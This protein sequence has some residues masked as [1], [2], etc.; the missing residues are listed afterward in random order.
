MIEQTEQPSI[1]LAQ[2]YTPTVEQSRYYNIGLVRH[3]DGWRRHEDQRQPR[4][5]LSYGA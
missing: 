4:H 1:P 2:Q 3:R 5:G